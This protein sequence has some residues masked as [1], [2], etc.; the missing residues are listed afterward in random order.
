MR[1][2]HSIIAALML[3]LGLVTGVAGTY[4]W[5]G[6]PPTTATR[7]ARIT[8]ARDTCC[9]TDSAEAA[10]GHEEA[11][12]H[13]DEH[14]HEEEEGHADEQGHTDTLKLT[15]EAMRRFQVKVDEARA[16]TIEES[17][18]L[19]GEIVLN[20]DRV[21]HIVPR[22]AGMVRETLKSAGDQVKTGDVLAALDSRELAEAKAA[23]LTAEARLKLAETNL[24]RTEGLWQ[25]K[26]VPERQ[27]QEAT[28]TVEEA[29]IVH[30]EAIARLHALGL[31]HPE[32]AGVA[33]A[34]QASFARYEIRA[35]F[36]G[37]I[38]EK[39]ATLGEVHDTTGSMFVLAD[40]STVWVEVTVY[41][42]DVRRVQR[43]TPIRVV[44]TGGGDQP[45]IVAEGKVF[46]VS[47]TL[48]E[49]TR[50]GMARAV[51]DNQ[52]GEW[53]PGTFVTAEIV[54]ATTHAEVCVPTE[55]IQQVEGESVVFVACGEGFEKRHVQVG[56]ADRSTSQILS[57]LSAGE[58]YVSAG[59]FILKA[60]LG[61]GTGGHEH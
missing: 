40:L 27:Y 32:V 19:P 38:I 37:T 22:V 33:E 30:R 58:R 1:T 14:A 9:P 47:P 12:P 56:T 10:H 6:A 36:A 13:E 43:D 29:S 54:T 50:T 5:V 42:Q 3:M 34:D 48:R 57:G 18:V 2:R 23:D 4:R 53:R 52:R 35:P 55:A 26:I 28:Q 41:A 31:T 8:L 21:A 11:A 39:H 49:S 25:Q 17:I 44:Q 59:A 61:K 51:I 60:E 15:E 7:P 24:K 16:G 45:A 20:A 46:Y